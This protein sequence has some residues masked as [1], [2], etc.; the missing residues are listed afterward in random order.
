MTTTTVTMKK[1][2]TGLIAALI[3]ALVGIGAWVYQLTAGMQVTGLGN[4]IVW[5]LY[6][7]A[8][9]TAVGTGA[10]LLVLTGVSE[11]LP[12]IPSEKRVRTLYLSFSSLVVG[13]LLITLDVGNP[14]QIWRIITAF[15]FSSMMTWDFW[16]LAIAA[17]VVLVYLLAARGNKA[18]KVWGMLGILS[19]MVV[20]IVEGWMLSAQA[21]HPMWGSGL[22]VLTF[23][24]G[25]GI[26]G[27]SVALLGDMTNEKLLGWLKV[28][29]GL[30]LVFAV[31]EVLTGLVGG[32]EEISLVL[33]GFAAPAFWL[34]L[35]VGLLVPMALLARKTS[36]GLAAI[37][38]V[39]GVLAE[40]VWMLAAGS[41]F[42]WMPGQQGVYSPSWVEIVA[43][44]G[45]VAIGVLIYRLLPVLFKTE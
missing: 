14:V 5:G 28:A 40:K 44:I 43:V 29:L 45:M 13:G 19:G 38:A 32:E 31:V 24:L 15:K 37:L 9:F 33:T 10:G 27:I 7:A 17:V 20:V 6:I 36:V 16:L 42:P 21:A 30:S 4:Q 12:V 41:A 2:N 23:L 3:L 25:A 35:V 26:A 22:T 34:Q 39:F 18:Q 8:F 1:D 11:Y